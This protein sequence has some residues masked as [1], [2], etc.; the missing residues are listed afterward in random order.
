MTTLNVGIEGGVSLS[1]E[2]SKDGTGTV[3]T[4]DLGD[5]KD[6]VV[7]ICYPRYSVAMGY[8]QIQTPKQNIRGWSIKPMSKIYRQKVLNGSASTQSQTKR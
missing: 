3:I 8:P 6:A 4:V 5:L 7:R 2:Q 1:V